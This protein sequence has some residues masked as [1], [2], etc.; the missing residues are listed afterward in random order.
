MKRCAG[1]RLVVNSPLRRHRSVRSTR[2]ASS[3]S[4]RRRNSNQ[5]RVCGPDKM[6][7]TGTLEATGY[8]HRAGVN[9]VALLDHL[10]V[11]R[12]DYVGHSPGAVALLFVGTQH[13]NRVRTL[14][15]VGGTTPGTM[16]TT[17]PTFAG[18]WPNGRP[19]LDESTSSASA[20][21]RP[22]GA[23]TGGG[24]SASSTT[25]TTGW[26]SCP[27]D[28]RTWLG[29]RARC[30]YCRATATGGFRSALPRRCT[31]RCRMPS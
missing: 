25:C 8:Y 19:I 11:E 27:S 29:S 3:S 23:T 31:R 14:T 7:S 28:P 6:R 20:T 15:L 5:H 30:W 21:T 18:G 17:A 2:S 24:C 13:P 26:M 16:R 22:I 10:D 4:Q 9:L 12:A 1:R